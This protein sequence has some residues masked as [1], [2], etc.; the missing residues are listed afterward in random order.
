MNFTE[1]H[2]AMQTLTTLAR[3]IEYVACHAYRV[4]RTSSEATRL[5]QPQMWDMANW[6]AVS[7][8]DITQ[9]RLVEKVTA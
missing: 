6:M 1:L 8:S 4:Y 9:K 3:R 5:M 7:D 2:Q